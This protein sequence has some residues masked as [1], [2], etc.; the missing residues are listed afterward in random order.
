MLSLSLDQQHYAQNERTEFQQQ[1]KKKKKS[2]VSEF[3]LLEKA[4]KLYTAMRCTDHLG[5]QHNKELK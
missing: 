3:L 4:V 1:R 2:T 5:F